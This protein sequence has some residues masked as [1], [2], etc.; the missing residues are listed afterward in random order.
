MT[1]RNR[2]IRLVLVAFV[3]LALASVAGTAFAAVT[4][5][6]VN[7]RATLTNDRT[8]AVISGRIQCA[9]GEGVTLNVF[10]NQTLNGNLVT[11]S[12]TGTQIVC[13]GTL[14]EWQVT[15]PGFLG[16]KAGPAIVNVQAYP[17][18]I[19]N[20]FCPPPSPPV[21]TGATVHLGNR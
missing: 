12:G 9:I 17:F 20:P 8:S 3:A 21:Q 5:L 16:W 6:T 2:P 7:N 14:Q 10:I 19:C 11:G 13:D 18:P 15:A 4:T 1:R